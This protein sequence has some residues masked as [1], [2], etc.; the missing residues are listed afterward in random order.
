MFDIKEMLQKGCTKSEKH[1]NLSL[2]K[3]AGN[4]YW[5]LLRFQTQKWYTVHICSVKADLRTVSLLEL[6]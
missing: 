2:R 6:T 1:T 3:D 5:S 4:K